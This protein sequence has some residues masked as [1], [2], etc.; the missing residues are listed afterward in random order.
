MNGAVPEG[1]ADPESLA[2]LAT[3]VAFM[4]A[5]VMGGELNM[6]SGEEVCLVSRFGSASRSSS[7]S[8]EEER[9]SKSEGLSM[10]FEK[11]WS[12]WGGGR[13]ECALL[14]QGDPPDYETR[15]LK[16]DLGLQGLSGV[17]SVSVCK[18]G[19]GWLETTVR[20]QAD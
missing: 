18:K 10:G 6:S 11:S 8:S 4:V 14:E 16:V 2:L 7:T 20:H 9:S 15:L 13:G 1:L 5:A 19:Q 17:G 3:V 12:R